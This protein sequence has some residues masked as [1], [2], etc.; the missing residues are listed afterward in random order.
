M[1]LTELINLMKVREYLLIAS[2]NGAFDKPTIHYLS[3]TLL[4]VDKK[5]VELLK[6]D[7]FK[8]YVNFKDVKKAIQEVVNLNDIQSTIRYK[9]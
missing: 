9:T 6:G 2:N 1:D 5:I 7:E 4:L 3:N 8:E